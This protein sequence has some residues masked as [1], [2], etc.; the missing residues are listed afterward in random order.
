M[1]GLKLQERDLL[2]GGRGVDRRLGRV[3]LVLIIVTRKDQVQHDYRR[4][5][6]TSP[7]AS[8]VLT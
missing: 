3:A 5:S 8:G 6:S 1:Q 4:A 2:E 7:A